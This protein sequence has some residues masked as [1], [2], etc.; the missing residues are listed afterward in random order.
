MKKFLSTIII[1]G[2]V[3]L[4]G[5]Y[6]VKPVPMFGAIGIDDASDTGLTSTD[7]SNQVTL[8]HTCT[9]SDLTL[10]VTVVSGE[11]TNVDRDVTGITYNGTAMTKEQELNNDDEHVLTE[12]WYLANPSTGA[13][14]VVVT[15]AGA[16][17]AVIVGAVS[18]SGTNTSDPVDVSG[19]DFDTSETSS[20]S[21]TVT[22]NNDNSILIDSAISEQGSA[23]KISVGA[24]QIE[25][26]NDDMGSTFG[27]SSTEIGG[28]AGNY[29]MSWTDSDNDEM[30]WSV[31]IAINEAGGSPPV[32]ECTYSGS[33]DWYIGTDTCYVTSNTYV[34][35]AVYCVDAGAIVVNGAT[36]VAEKIM[37]QPIT[38]NSGKI[39]IRNLN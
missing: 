7:V 23:D 29:T 22:T 3:G 6:L 30:W 15:F 9:G 5:W 13:N 4:S 1:A 14:D 34:N 2:L 25:R 38:R 8:S 12:I 31:V 33:G 24:D 10:V 27:L 17:D 11:F 19:S 16:N 36:L 35:G 20:P 26:Y 21:V 28:N 18:I 37:C 32:S 39:I